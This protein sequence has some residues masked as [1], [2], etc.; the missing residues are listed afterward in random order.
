MKQV[1]LI[2]LCYLVLSVPVTAQEG[3]SSEASYRAYLGNDIKIVKE[4]WKKNVADR[5]AFLNKNPLDE[6]A[7]YQL[8]LAQFGLLTS[9]M[10]DKDEDLFD[11]YADDAENNLESL[12]DKN[13]KWGEPRALLSA[14][15]GLRMGYSPWKGMY[16]G[17]KSQSLMDKALKDAPASPLVWKLYANSKFFTPETWG[18]DLNEAIKAYEKSVSLYES[19]P[20]KIK[21]NWFYLDTLA[22]LGQA[23][24]KNG[25]TAN[26]IVS[27][28]KAL[29]AE[30]N[31][32]WVKLHLLP[33]A[34]KN[35]AT[36]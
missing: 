24:M 12:M 23:Y 35:T 16:L 25:Q 5:R 36:Y 32:S 30:P 29:K 13:K 20:E 18:G 14:V 15:Y 21:W 27:Y 9:T 26:A 2:L 8:A 33:K 10:R 28:E 3:E 22:F 6:N 17:S 4:L 11:E 19:N 34:K 1:I 31:F 7:L